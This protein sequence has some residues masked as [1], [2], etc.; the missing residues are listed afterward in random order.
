MSQLVLRFPSRT[1]FHAEDLLPNPAQDE[2]RVWLVRTALWP[3]RRLVLVGEAGSGKSH[4]LHAWAEAHGGI[5]LPHA[6]AGYPQ[7]PVALDSLDA[8]PDEAAL[9]HFLNAAV[10]AGQ[11][12]L[13]AASRP[14]PALPIGLPDL[15]SRLRATT[16]VT[17]GPAPDDFLAL[18]LARLVAEHQLRLPPGLAPFLLARLPRHPDAIRSAVLRLEAGAQTTRVLSRAS[19]AAILGL[20]DT[21][22]TPSPAPAAFG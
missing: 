8:V 12:V 1:A 13:L 22:A 4:L 6:P 3:S 2:A 5:V 11:P 14:P 18:L 20:H 16:T 21:S 10:E 9:F 7:G 19:A 17:I 15:R